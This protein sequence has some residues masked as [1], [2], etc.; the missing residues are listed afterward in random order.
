MSV[1]LSASAPSSSGPGD[2]LDLDHALGQLE[3]RLDRVGQAALDAL[4]PHQ[5]VDH[6]LDRV[7]LVPGQPVAVLQEVR[8]VD[9]VA[10]DPG[11]HEALGGQVLQQRLVLAL[12]PPHDGRQDLEAGAVRQ[13]RQAVDDLL[14]ALPLQPYAVLRAVREADAGPQEAQ[15]VVDLGDGADRRAR[16]AGRRLLVDRDGRRQ[17]FDEVDVRLVHLAQEL[18]GVGAQRLDVAALTLGV[19]GVEGQ[20]GLA[21]ARQPGEHDELVARQFDADVLQVVL[22]GTPHDDGVGHLPRPYRRRSGRRRSNG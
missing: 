17:A 4:T 8:D 12:P 22:A 20:R 19:D 3:R 5:A 6:H 2:D 7:L 9:G 18:A 1:S 15:V 11:P 16:V 13:L 10:V 21:R 14:W